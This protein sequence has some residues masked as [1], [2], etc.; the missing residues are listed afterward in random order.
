[1]KTNGPSKLQIPTLSQIR[2]SSWDLIFLEHFLVVGN[3]SC[4]NTSFLSPYSSSR[5]SS[6]WFIILYLFSFVILPLLGGGELPLESRSSWYFSKILMNLKP[7]IHLW[8]M[9]PTASKLLQIYA[10][11]VRQTSAYLSLLKF[12]RYVAA[13]RICF[14]CN[15]FASI[16]PPWVTSWGGGEML[17]LT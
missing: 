14:L 8:W 9:A 16:R 5:I 12:R 3:R 13:S 7:W 10:S 1:M 4:K 11:I 2:Q 17:N 6:S 15:L